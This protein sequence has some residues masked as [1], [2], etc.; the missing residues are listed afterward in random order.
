MAVLLPRLDHRDTSQR[1]VAPT[2]HDGHSGKRTWRDNPWRCSSR[3]EGN[4]RGDGLGWSYWRLFYWPCKVWVGVPPLPDCPSSRR[5][6]HE[7]PSRS[8]LWRRKEGM[9][10]PSAMP[11]L[12]IIMS[13]IHCSASPPASPPIS[14]TNNDKV[15]KEQ[16][17]GTIPEFWA[18]KFWE[19]PDQR[20]PQNFAQSRA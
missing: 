12:S 5:F 3:L 13:R 16:D 20:W 4:Y 19:L 9:E 6:D 1:E 17:W 10:V 18:R 8:T 7:A 15:T 11:L 14:P 2:G